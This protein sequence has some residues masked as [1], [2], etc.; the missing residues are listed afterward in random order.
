MPSARSALPTLALCLCF[1][2]PAAADPVDYVRQVK[3]ILARHCYEC[4]NAK[5]QK[6]KLRAD[7]ATFLLKGGRSGAAVVP[8]K[9][10]ESGLIEAVR[11]TDGVTPMPYKRT[12]LT[13]A[14]IGLLTTWIDQGARA[15]ANEK[16]DDGSSSHWAF[17]PPVRPPLPAVKDASW[18]RNPIDHFILAR[19]EKEGIPP[20]P[21]ADRATL[22]RRLY[23]DLLGLPP[24]VAD[25]DAFV[26][27]ARPDAYERLVERLLAS[28]H[29]GERWGRHWLD[30]ARYADS[31]G[32]TIDTPREIWQ[33]R[34]WVIDALN[35]DLPFDQFVIEQFAGDMLPHATTAQKIATGFHRNT[36]INEEG[37]I[38]VEQFR[39]EAVAD[40]VNTTGIAFLGLTLGCARCHDHKYDPITT[41]EYYQLFAFLNNQSEPT[42]SLASPELAAKRKVIRARIDQIEEALDAP[43]KDALAKLPEAA[44]GKVGRDL[45]VIL[46]LRPD[47]RSESQKRR[48]AAFFRAKDPRF[49]QGFD[50][51]DALKKQ[52]PKFPTTLVMAEL[53]RPRPSFVMLGGDFTRKGDKVEPG[54]PAVLHPLSALQEGEGSKTQPHR[55]D[56][57]RWLV[58]R[59]NP[60]VGRVTMN[61]LWQHYFG[62]GLVDTE[63][64][65]GTQGSPPT[66]PALLD[67]LATEFPEGGW[68]LKAMH[69][70]MVCSATYRQTSRVR[71]ELAALDPQ[72]RLLARQ[73]RLRLDAEIVRD[74]AL[75]ASGLL[76]R[77]LGGPSVHPPQPDGIYQ[78]T[79]VQRPWQTSAGPARYRRGIYTFFQRSAPYPALIVFDAPDS[80][81]TCTRRVRSNTPLQALTLLNDQAFLELARGLAQR[82]LQQAGP[83]DAQRL[84]HAFRLCLARTPGP[85]E[86]ERLEQYLVQQLEEFRAAPAEAQALLEG[87]VRKAPEAGS[88]KNR[89]GVNQQAEDA[90]LSVSHSVL[91]TPYSVPERAAWTAMARVLLNLDEFI[92]R[93]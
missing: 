76:S 23:L 59:R 3:P 82:V 29:Y 43:L 62:K 36:L 92:T 37:G 6:G 84:R 24:D 28:P 55:L 40:R 93:E 11:G 2:V 63:N 67:W 68:S 80:T 60:L 61:R 85:A 13:K 30:V 83:D 27:D 74:N 69:R 53:P 47:Q 41:R 51:I 8:G 19:L 17:R 44:T 4:H 88:R 57:A 64:D 77:Q 25:V 18:V 65:F 7:T 42:L 72:N 86:V 89:A 50:E 75:A 10:A 78:F 52:E 15:P 31:N 20:S 34:D 54:V 9:A 81:S 58:D 33:Y 14:E 56:L 45:Q 16:P 79:Q 22:I 73:N 38:D 12:P 87:G 46:N 21:Q 26:A 91:G 71:P 48:L 39:V 70:L 49:K 90:A 5:V 32:F 35:R 1:A 66:H